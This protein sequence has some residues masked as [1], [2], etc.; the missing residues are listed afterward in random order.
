M[1]L[2][3]VIEILKTIKKINVKMH[4]RG[5]KQRKKVHNLATLKD[6]HRYKTIWIGS[7]PFSIYLLSNQEK[8]SVDGL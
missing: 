3:I 2:N 8:G 5:N 7:L 4:M 6:A 1:R